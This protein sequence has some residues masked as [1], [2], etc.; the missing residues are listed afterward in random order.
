MGLVTPFLFMKGA[1]DLI[2]ASS[3]ETALGMKWEERNADTLPETEFGEET[4]WSFSSTLNSLLF[5]FILYAALAVFLDK[6]L[7]NEFGWSKEKFYFLCDP[8]SLLGKG[9]TKAAATAAMFEV[10]DSLEEDVKT[11]AA[12]VLA[13]E[14]GDTRKA[15]V[16]R[17]LKKEFKSR[18]WC[19]W[20]PWKCGCCCK[21]ENRG[22]CC[23]TSVHN[24]VDGIAYSVDEDTVFALLGHNGAGK[25]TTINLLTGLMPISG[26]DATI[27][28]HSVE[29]EMNRISQIMGVCPQHDI[30]WEQL[31]G[32]EHIEL[33]ARIKATQGS[34][35]DVEE[36]IRMRLKDVL[37]DNDGDARAG[38]YSGG[39]KR[40]LSV[41]LALVG[42]PRV[43]F[44]VSAKLSL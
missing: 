14:L 43:V 25:S 17:G 36:E 20:K 28:G 12:M 31:T 27:S 40:R 7:P 22:A 44:F 35:V 33:F 8:R 6:T 39:M 15:I 5:T 18:S 10:S 38:A 37:L 26:G 24:A 11:E 16:V 1:T 4:F 32:K 29:H 19:G 3:G 9:K 42:N 21:K 23:T 30:L 41:A 34:T 2:G 13:N